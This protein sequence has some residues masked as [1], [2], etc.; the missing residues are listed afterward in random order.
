M[1]R[2][3]GMAAPVAERRRQSDFRQELE[4]LDFLYDRHVVSAEEYRSARD[5]LERHYRPRPVGSTG[6]SA[7]L[8]PAFLLLVASLSVA[9][10]GYSLDPNLKHLYWPQLALVLVVLATGLRLASRVAR[11]G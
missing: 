8:R 3:T 1:E 4:R 2:R 9:L 10:I 7:L 6:G 5:R 11:G